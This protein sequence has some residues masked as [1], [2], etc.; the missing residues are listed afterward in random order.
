MAFWSSTRKKFASILI[1]IAAVISIN[2]IAI[3]QI[4]KLFTKYKGAK[5]D[6]VVVAVRDSM[7]SINSYLQTINKVVDDNYHPTNKELDQAIKY[8]HQLEVLLSSKIMLN[9]EKYRYLNQKYGFNLA[10]YQT[11]KS[12]Q[13]QIPLL[14]ELLTRKGIEISKGH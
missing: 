1:T 7:I 5:R 3:N 12:L 6:P 14:R 11:Y 2:T 8:L 4:N 9:D 10:E 13:A